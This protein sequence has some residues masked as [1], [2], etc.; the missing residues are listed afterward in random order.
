MKYDLL[1]VREMVVNY[2]TC[3]ER[4]DTRDMLGMTQSVVD[5]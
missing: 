3:N 5:N 1:N 2:F 4:N